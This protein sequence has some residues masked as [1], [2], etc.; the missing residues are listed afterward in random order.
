[1][2]VFESTVE[3]LS[4]GLV[5]L[6]FNNIYALIAELYTIQFSEKRD[7]LAPNGL[8]LAGNGNMKTVYTD[9]MV[10]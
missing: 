10:S 3:V 6:M 4:A 8:L 9:I 7:A 2:W 1:M 5:Q